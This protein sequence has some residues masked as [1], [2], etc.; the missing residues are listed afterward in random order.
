MPNER[1]HEDAAAE[2]RLDLEL[3]EGPRRE[4]GAPD[5]PRDEQGRWAGGGDGPSTSERY[6]QSA[7]SKATPTYKAAKAASAAHHEAVME[8]A[9][10]VKSGDEKRIAAAKSTM[11]AA[12]QKLEETKVAHWKAMERKDEYRVET[13]DGKWCIVRASSGDLVVSSRI[14]AFD[15]GQMR[16]EGGKWT[17]GGAPSLAKSEKGQAAELARS[18]EEHKAAASYH[19]TENAKHEKAGNKKAASAHAAA[20]EA[21]LTAIEKPHSISSIK[22]GIASDVAHE[23]ASTARAKLD[24]AQVR[25]FDAI[26]LDRYEVQPNGWIRIDDAPIARIGIQKYRRA[27]GSIRNELRLEE[28]VFHPDALASF[29]LVPVT[30]DH[31]PVGLLDAT[32]T[33]LYQRG[34]LGETVR[35]DGHTVRAALLITDAALI[36]KVKAGKR[37]LSCGYVCDLED[38]PGEWKGE[39]Y[40][41]VQRH[42]RGNHVAVVDAARGGPELRLRLDSQDAVSIREPHEVSPFANSDREHKESR[43]MATATKIDVGGIEVEVATEQGAQLVTRE[44]KSRADALESEK[45]ARAAAEKATA[46]VTAKF[47]S[48]KGRADSFETKMRRDQDWVPMC[49]SRA[50]SPS[51]ICCQGCPAKTNCAAICGT[52]V[53]AEAGAKMDAA[54]TRADA[55]TGFKAAVKSRVDFMAR[56]RKVLGEE[57]KIDDMDDLAIKK[58]VVAKLNPG[59]KLD[60]MELGYI[61][62]AYTGLLAVHEAGASQAALA[63]ARATSG[64]PGARQDAETE[65]L[66]ADA[67]VAKFKKDTEKAYLN[68]SL[69][70]KA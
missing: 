54:Q 33:S 6:A 21:H 17:G 39:K 66:D 18:P 23:A 41:C 7:K 13:R 53:P 32:N 5:Q 3:A 40:D 57:V 46:D 31:P 10:A 36:E 24:G 49:F 62:G 12:R 65:H 45:A 51:S 14:D 26:R 37:E 64:A 8:H 16:D 47:T 61:D 60:G 19:A 29:G 25:R 9:A 1:E 59:L 4:D 44:L 34:T 55:A 2:Q 15:P 30:D 11:G 63:K 67:A 28:E 35:K 69:G 43:P 22:A 52:V 38:A 58:A 68:P 20:L 42:V 70:V 27:D 50:C 48:E 56:A